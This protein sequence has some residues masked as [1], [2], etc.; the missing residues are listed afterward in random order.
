V[1]SPK[2]V[3]AAL[4]FIPA[5]KLERFSPRFSD[6]GRRAS[7]RD[8]SRSVV[9]DLGARKA[10]INVDA[11]AS[12]RSFNQRTTRERDDEVAVVLERRGTNRP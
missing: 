4:M 10:R 7:A 5:W 11:A 9:E 3:T 6:S 12:L 8:D 1:P 2:T